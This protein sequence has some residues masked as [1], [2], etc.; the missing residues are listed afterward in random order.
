M[1][2]RI[3][4]ASPL[5]TACDWAKGYEYRAYIGGADSR[6]IFGKNDGFVDC[7][8]EFAGYIAEQL[9]RGERAIILHFKGLPTAT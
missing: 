3:L 4:V 1:K 2:D 6:W 8:D 9:K 7:G 5:T